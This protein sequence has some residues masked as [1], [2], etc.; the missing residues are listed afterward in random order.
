MPPST[1]LAVSVVSTGNRLSG[2]RAHERAASAA[3]HTVLIFVCV[4]VVAPCVFLLLGSFKSVAEFFASPFGLPQH[5]GVAN[6]TQAW[7]E[8]SVSTTLRNSV[9]VT[10]SAVLLSTAVACLASYAIARLPSLPGRTV[11]RLIFIGGLIVPVQLIMIAL[12]IIMRHLGLLNTLTS[13]I[14]VYSTF[15]IPLAVLVLVGFFQAL[16]HEITEA[17]MIDGA[18]HFRTFIHIVLPL[19]KAAIFTVIILNGVWMWNDFFIALVLTSN[20][21]IATLPLG[22]LNFFGVYS[23]EWGL[24]FASVVIAALPVVVLYL[25]MTKRFIAA[26]TAGSAGG[27]HH[28]RREHRRRRRD[29]QLGIRARPHRRGA[30]TGLGEATL[31]GKAETIVAAVSELARMVVGQDPARIQHLWQVMY[32]HSF[33]RG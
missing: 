5:F 33:W 28:W 21:S 31:E 18:N 25:L 10:A 24:I 15:G 22:I 27:H 19:S 4:L 8:A 20:P 9:I 23:T 30:C 1:S 17:A 32:R 6:Y 29:A 14:I 26:L 2:R 3:S 11:W 12:F 13:L 7:S 16:P